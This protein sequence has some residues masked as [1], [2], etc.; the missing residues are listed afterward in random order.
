MVGKK[1]QPHHQQQFLSQILEKLVAEQPSW[2]S[3]VVWINMRPSY[4]SS[5]DDSASV[6]EDVPLLLLDTVDGRVCFGEVHLVGTM[7]SCAV[8]EERS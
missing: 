1:L 5:C 8:S 7:L 4:I 2:N 6:Q 3:T